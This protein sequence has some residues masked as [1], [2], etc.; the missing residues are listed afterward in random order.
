M[1]TELPQ[2][3]SSWS[4]G[5]H[6]LH[7]KPQLRLS[8]SGL[9]APTFVFIASAARRLCLRQHNNNNNNN[10]INTDANFYGAIIMAEPL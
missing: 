1:L 2:T 10:N 8:P 5:V 7:P 6:C 3:P 4:N 9:A